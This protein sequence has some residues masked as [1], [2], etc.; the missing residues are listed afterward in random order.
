[1]K[2]NIDVDFLSEYILILILLYT[3]VT[4]CN[5]CVNQTLN[6]IP[7][8]NDCQTF[9]LCWLS[10]AYLQTCPNDLFFDIKTN[11]SFIL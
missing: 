7:N 1:M 3:S 6:A 4:L 11:V 9:I 10:H 5:P 8:P 2:Y